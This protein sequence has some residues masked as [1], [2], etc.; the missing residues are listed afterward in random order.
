[1]KSV[2]LVTAIYGSVTEQTHHPHQTP[3]LVNNEAWWVL[4][5]AEFG[6]IQFLYLWLSSVTGTL[7]YTVRLKFIFCL[8]TMQRNSIPTDFCSSWAGAFPWCDACHRA[9]LSQDCPVCGCDVPVL[10]QATSLNLFSLNIKKIQLCNG[11]RVF[12]K[13]IWANFK[14]I[15]GKTDFFVIQRDSQSQNKLCNIIS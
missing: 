6:F 13:R 4:C 10:V 3:A 12:G 11:K 1:M 8:E 2:E 7:Y 15:S 9:W 5:P 14:V